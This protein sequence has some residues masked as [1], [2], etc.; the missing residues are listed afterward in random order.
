MGTESVNGGTYT[1][2]VFFFGWRILSSDSIVNVNVINLNTRVPFL[3]FTFL[4][5]GTKWTKGTAYAGSVSHYVVQDVG[6]TGQVP[7]SIPAC[8]RKSQ[9]TPSSPKPSGTSLK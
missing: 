2:M 7:S 5:G 4:Q 8:S 6:L 1:F 3:R 9:N